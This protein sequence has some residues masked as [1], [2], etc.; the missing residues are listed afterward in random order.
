MN[1]L[2]ELNP[3]LEGNIV[4]NVLNT[5]MTLLVPKAQEIF[6][7]E[8]PMTWNDIGKKYGIEPAILVKING[9]NVKMGDL[10]MIPTEKQAQD[11]AHNIFGEDVETML[12]ELPKASTLRQ[13]A[14][15]MNIPEYLHELFFEMNLASENDTSPGAIHGVE[16][17]LP[18]ATIFAVPTPRDYSRQFI[19]DFSQN[20]TTY[21]IHITT[22]ENETPESIMHFYGI[23]P[24]VF[25]KLNPEIPLNKKL[26]TGSK[27]KTRDTSHLLSRVTTVVNLP[28]NVIE[29]V[30]LQ[31]MGTKKEGYLR[32]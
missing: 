3:H 29:F 23:T 19:A 18:P 7:L 10:I 28:K 8:E 2:Y 12:Y 30:A 27:V 25:Q 26:A 6:R 1:H 9:T 21:D 32:N 5:D 17:L 24:E 11:I 16:Q 14:L 4:D 15:F 20:H 22:T 31:E 13:I